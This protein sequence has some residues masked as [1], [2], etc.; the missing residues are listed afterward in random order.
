[1][2]YD[3]QTLLY[4]PSPAGNDTINQLLHA[5]LDHWY[6]VTCNESNFFNEQC[7]GFTQCGLAA[8]NA[9]ADRP[10]AAAG[11][12]SA[13]VESVITPAAW[14]GEYVYQ[15]QVGSGPDRRQST[16]AGRQPLF[17]PIAHGVFASV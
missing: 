9:V 2:F 11:N 6:G 13:L 4:D 12:L 14:Y 16:R 15:Y 17:S 10:Q 1:M 5:S 3:L 7:R 8:M